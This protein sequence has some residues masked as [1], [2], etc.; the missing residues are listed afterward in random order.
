VVAVESDGS[1]EKCVP[2]QVLY[3][4]DLSVNVLNV[5]GDDVDRRLLRR[6]RKSLLH[7]A[8]DLGLIVGYD[9]QVSF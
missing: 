1:L 2:F 3:A 4:Q 9:F 5:L 6:G 8:R 7:N